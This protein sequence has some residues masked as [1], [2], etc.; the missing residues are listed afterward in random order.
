ME[1]YYSSQHIYKWLGPQQRTSELKILGSNL[2]VN[3]STPRHWYFIGY[4]FAF[5][6]MYYSLWMALIESF[7]AP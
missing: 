5:S 3:V 4:I 7:F 6:V 1:S 2:L